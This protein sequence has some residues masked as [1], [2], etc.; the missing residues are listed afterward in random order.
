MRFTLRRLEWPIT[1]KVP[2]LVML[3]MLA[4]SM[5][6]SNTVLTRLAETQERHLQTL[7]QA[8]L[9]GLSGTLLPLFFARMFG[10]FS[11]R[12]TAHDPSMQGFTLSRRLYLILRTVSSRRVIPRPSRP[13][14][15]LRRSFWTGLNNT[16]NS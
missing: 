5:V 11:T 14:G 7:S 8:Y 13:V 6:I 9:D 10:R 15:R 4:I 3:L 12:L 1:I 2:L 16:V